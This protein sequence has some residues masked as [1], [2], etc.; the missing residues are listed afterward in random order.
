MTPILL[1]S[2]AK[3]P[4]TQI[5][6]SSTLDQKCGLIKL[7]LEDLLNK[8]SIIDELHHND[9]KID[10][11]FP[12]GLKIINSNNF[13]LINRVISIPE[14]IFNDFS[15]EDK[16][17]S[18][19]EFRAYLTFAIEAFPNSFSK[20]GPFGLSGN[21]FS[22]PR[23]WEMIK[24]AEFTC[25]TPKYYLGHM[26]FCPLEGDLVYSNPF[27]FY[28][29]KPNQLV[30]IDNNSFAFLRPK[31]KPVVASLVGDNVQVFCCQTNDEIHSKMNLLLEEY[32]AQIARL[33]NYPIAEILFFVED[34]SFI[35]GMISNIPYASSKKEWFF[36]DICAY[37]EEN[38]LENNGKN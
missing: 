21:R 35:F 33:F 27:D 5:L 3:E 9:V 23:Q 36:E 12:N 38:L 10:W 32:A 8:A 14:E 37:F 20:P 34:D 1:Y 24:K 19:S 26:D 30:D 29:W 28:Y 22:L 13:Y 4:L 16:L 15:E 7:S 11:T 25:N 31:G 18:M 17:Y 2:H 6:L